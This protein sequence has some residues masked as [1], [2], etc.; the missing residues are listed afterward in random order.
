[1][2][3]DVTTIKVHRSTR[4][5]LSAIADTFGRGTTLDQVLNDL[6]KRYETDEVRAR[7]AAEQLHAEVRADS[8]LMNRAGAHADAH[9]AYLTERAAHQ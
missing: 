9:L 4:D 7:Q 3:A 1:M 2:T 8:A 5:R 6:V